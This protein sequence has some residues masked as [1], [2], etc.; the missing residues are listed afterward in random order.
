MSKYNVTITEITE[1]TGDPVFSWMIK[2]LA[3][4]FDTNVWSNSVAITAAIIKREGL[5]VGDK[6]DVR[7]L[8]ELRDESW[9]KMDEQ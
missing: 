4:V 1:W 5:K 6:M 3:V 7:N 8:W 9:I 2:S